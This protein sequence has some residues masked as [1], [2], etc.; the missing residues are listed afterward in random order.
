MAW[1][2]R[3][4]NWTVML[5]ICALLA[6]SYPLLVFLAGGEHMWDFWVAFGV[7]V[8][9]Y[10]G[11]YDWALSEKGWKEPNSTMNFGWGIL[12]LTGWIG[13]AVLLLVKNKRQ[14]NTDKTG[15]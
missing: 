14:L 13:V 3:H 11:I 2:K 6:I 5:S 7:A 8:V 1:F 4:I 15:E 9:V 12:W 10:Y